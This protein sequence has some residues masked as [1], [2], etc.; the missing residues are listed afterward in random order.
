MK[1]QKKHMD[2]KKLF[3]KLIIAGF[4]LGIVAALNR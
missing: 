2:I 4:I 1:K 3:P